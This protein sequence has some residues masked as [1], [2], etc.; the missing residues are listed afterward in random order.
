MCC[1][2]T[3]QVA[4]LDR[5]VAF[6]PYGNV[7]P[8]KTRQCDRLAGRLLVSISLIHSHNETCYE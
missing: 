8:F 1:L 5:N 7:E 6:H 4:V 2:L 3:C